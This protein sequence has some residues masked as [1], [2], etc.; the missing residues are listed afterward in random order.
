M[1]TIAVVVVVGAMDLW[2]SQLVPSCYKN[3]S[4]SSH[5]VGLAKDGKYRGFDHKA[6]KDETIRSV[7]KRVDIPRPRVPSLYQIEGY[8]PKMLKERNPCP[9][10]GGGAVAR[11]NLRNR[12]DVQGPEVGR[13]LHFGVQCFHAYESRFTQLT[14]ADW[15]KI[16]QNIV[17]ATYLLNKPANLLHKQVADQ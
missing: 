15:E 9:V 10:S 17:T 2:R 13:Q 12:A 5:T 11:L 14:L 8:P 4:I 7:M 3:I 1:D 16:R 6:E